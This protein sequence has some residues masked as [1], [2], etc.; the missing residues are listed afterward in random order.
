MNII[1]QGN[2]YEI[3]FN[4][5]TDSKYAANNVIGELE[6]NHSWLE[7]INVTISSPIGIRSGDTYLFGSLLPN[8]HYIVTCEFKILEENKDSNIT[9]SVSTTTNET[10]LANNTVTVNLIEYLDGI[11]ASDLRL[12]FGEIFKDGK[13][14]LYS[15]SVP[16][17]GIELPEIPGETVGD[18][19]IIKFTDADAI[20]YYRWDGNQWIRIFISSNVESRICLNTV[21]PPFIPLD[22]K[23]PTT[24][25]VQTWANANLTTLQRTNG[26][27]LVYY[28]DGDGGSCDNPDYIWTLNQGSELITLSNKRVFA[29]KIVYVDADSGSDVTGRR[30]YREFPFKTLDAA[31]AVLEDADELIHNS[32]GEIFSG[33]NI[34]P[35]LSNYYF[36]FEKD[37]TLSGLRFIGTGLPAPSSGVA[38]N[39]SIKCDRTLTK[40][41]NGSALVSCKGSVNSN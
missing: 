40:T 36:D 5:Y 31:I 37:I 30:G 38:K 27:Q 29:S 17:T 15:R 39:I 21:T 24:Q 32:S 19:A 25:E 26:T 10:D 9:W 14:L 2:N 23:N 4:L 6:Y 41:T 18:T 8:K 1:E 33:T 22:T 11:L 12:V 13:L 34:A 3:A 28:V 35:S 20:V 16:Y 7:L